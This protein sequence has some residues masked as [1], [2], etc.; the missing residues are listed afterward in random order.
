MTKYWSLREELY[1]ATHQWIT[2]VV[3]LILGCLLG[4]AGAFIWPSYYRATAQIYV[5]L[6]PYRAFSDTR[7]LALALPKY[8][9]ID[10][11]K[12]WQMSQLESAIFLDA[13]LQSTLQELRQRDAYWHDKDIDML[14]DMLEAEWRSAGTWSLVARDPD[15]QR[16]AQAAEAWSKVSVQRVQEAVHSARDTFILDQE[17]QSIA[18]QKT[19][20]STRIHALFSTRQALLEQSAQIQASPL[21][22]PLEPVDRWQILS[23]AGS[24]AQFTPAWLEILDSQP[25]PDAPAADYIPWIDKVTAHIQSEIFLLQKQ[26]TS[27]EQDRQHLSEQYAEASDRSLGLSPNLEVQGLKQL[28]PEPVRPTG[29]LIILGGLTGLLIWGLSRLVIITT[30]K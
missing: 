3:F 10:D 22:K 25:D 12:N 5:G 14:Q 23:L 11:Y 13:F 18:D 24:L 15:A 19:A 2:I 20:A 17:L 4:W 7:F 21:D 8:S 1:K 9:N 28:A 16:A 27:L 29:L 6:N 30:R 26:F